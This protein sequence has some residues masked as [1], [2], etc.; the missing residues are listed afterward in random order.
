MCISTAWALQGFWAGPWLADV[1]NLDRPEIVVGVLF[2]LA[3]ILRL[4]VPSIWF[5]RSSEAWGPQRF[6]VLLSWQNI[7]LVKS[8]VRPM[9]P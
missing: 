5:G 4:P 8:Q 6:S 7:F 3:L 2:K 1:E 9:P